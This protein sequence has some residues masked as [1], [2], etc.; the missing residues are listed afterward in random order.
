[1]YTWFWFY[2]DY[3][4]HFPVE[5]EQ[6]EPNPDHFDD[7]GRH[8][9]SRSMVCVIGQAGRVQKFGAPESGRFPGSRMLREDRNGRRRTARE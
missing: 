7:P 5:I 3:R 4:M 2:V 1:M 9:A 8:N 6:Q